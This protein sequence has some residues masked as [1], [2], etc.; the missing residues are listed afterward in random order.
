MNYL[1]ERYRTSD[2]RPYFNLPEFLNVSLT[3]LA[4]GQHNTGIKPK[5]GFIQDKT[6]ANDCRQISIS[7]LIIGAPGDKTEKDNRDMFKKAGAQPV[8]E[9]CAELIFYHHSQFCPAGGAGY[10]AGLYGGVVVYFGHGKTFEETLSLN[11]ADNIDPAVYFSNPNRYCLG[12]PTESGTCSICQKTG[13]LHTDAYYGPNKK[14]KMIYVPSPHCVV[15]DGKNQ[16]LRPSDPAEDVVFITGSTNAKAPNAVTNIS[17]CDSVNAFYYTF[18]KAKVLGVTEF[19]IL[20]SYC[21]TDFKILIGRS[22]DIIFDTFFREQG[23]KNTRSSAQWSVI[24]TSLSRIVL[25]NHDNGGQLVYKILEY[26]DSFI[27]ISINANLTKKLRDMI[28]NRKELGVAV[29]GILKNYYGFE[30]EQKKK[31]TKTKKDKTNV[32]NN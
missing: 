13:A 10:Q 26:Y 12:A 18:N 5:L 19:E 7:K 4:I 2:T 21:Q 30:F 25:E 16:Y 8:C 23:K 3:L 24:L 1:V 6:A 14:Q 31:K 17:K 15:I 28:T 29:W 9:H 22:A 20:K 11:S 32:T 27:P